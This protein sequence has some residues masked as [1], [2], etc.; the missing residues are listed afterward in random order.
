MDLRVAPSTRLRL[1]LLLIAVF[2]AMSGGVFA[3]SQ[4]ARAAGEAFTVNTTAD[5]IDAKPGDGVCATAAGACS[6]RAA[7]MEANA[8][9]S[10]ANSPSFFTIGLAGGQVYL[11][12]ISGTDEDEAA[13][14]D[15]DIR[16]PMSIV[17][18]GGGN[19]KVAG[20]R[21]W[22]DR[23]FDVN[24]DTSGG[25]VQLTGLTI[26]GGHAT[27]PSIEAFGGGLIAR[28]PRTLAGGGTTSYRLTLTDTT[29]ANNSADLDGGGIDLEGNTLILKSSTIRGNT[30]SGTTDTANGGGI[31]APAAGGTL[32]VT[33]S[34]VSG[35]AATRGFGGG[36]YTAGSMTLTN[37]TISGNA[38]GAGGGIN[39]PGN[40]GFTGG[41]T[42]TLS[43]STISG[44]ST[45]TGDGGGIL[46]GSGATVT[47]TNVTVAANTAGSPGAGISN[48]GSGG[49]VRLANTIVATNLIHNG[50]SSDCSG[51]LTSQGFNLI[52]NTDGCTLSGTTTGNI[53]NQEPRLGALAD[54][55][56]PTQTQA[57]LQRTASCPVKGRCPVYTPS[58]GIDAGN[59]ATVGSSSSACPSTDQRGIARPL[60]GNGDG[61]AQCDMGAYEAPA[62]PNLGTFTLTPSDGTA[63][64]GEHLTYTFA[65][66]VPF[67][68]WRSLDS[69]YVVLRDANG[70]ALWL[71]FHEVA[72]NG[73][74]L[75][76]V[77]PKDLKEGPSFTF[78][79][80]NRLETDA[81]TVY[82][83]NSTLNGPAG[84]DTVTLTMDLGFKPQALGRTFD[85]QVLAAND[86]GDFEGFVEAG[87]LK[88]EP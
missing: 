44:N 7:I 29:V 78:G 13:S 43:N 50:S 2:L 9:R 27:S 67:G 4:I 81:A 51:T 57:L 41:F 18:A 71:R 14:G 46:I 62:L 87:S 65:W 55:G 88:V 39:V 73:S 60:D 8:E 24:P 23:I 61:T 47:M 82:L 77:D 35:N 52:G 5:A 69:L 1:G 84:S 53:L 48:P 64:I 28:P 34:S 70:T 10:Q 86:A 12:S 31:N 75:N 20:T 42:A 59:P 76:L 6:L 32:T 26:E 17:V 56:G 16:V 15:L 79:S 83:A 58:Q 30:A 49:R 19:A 3:S 80:P 40:G 37:S 33:D 25:Q 54:N 22:N 74:T 11:L 36:I 85:V 66:T 72:G 21:G 68:G 45:N 38:A 63:H